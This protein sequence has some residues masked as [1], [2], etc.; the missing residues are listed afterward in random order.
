MGRRE[1]ELC[2]SCSHSNVYELTP[3]R[4]ARLDGFK[5]KLK[6]LGLEDAMMQFVGDHGLSRVT[7]GVYKQ[8]RCYPGTGHHTQECT[9]TKKVRC[10]KISKFKTKATITNGKSHHHKHAGSGH[11]SG[12]NCKSAIDPPQWCLKAFCRPVAAIS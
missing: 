12:E 8:T 4:R 6:S 2:V 10:E 7:C 5:D 11:G 3:F 9:S 1:H